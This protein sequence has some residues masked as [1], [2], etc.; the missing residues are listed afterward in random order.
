MASLKIIQYKH[1]AS[2]RARTDNTCLKAK[3]PQKSQCSKEQPELGFPPLASQIS[4][5]SQVA[6]TFENFNRSFYGE[7]TMLDTSR[8]QVGA[9]GEEICGLPYTRDE[10]DSIIQEVCAASTGNLHT[11]DSRPYLTN[12]SQKM[13]QMIPCPKH[14]LL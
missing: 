3:P 1:Q 6:G 10:I 11:I 8:V 2:K 12:S 7:T 9:C 13:V 4:P 5:L 14:L